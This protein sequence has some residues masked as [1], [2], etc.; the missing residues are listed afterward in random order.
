MISDL[1]NLFLSVRKESLFV[2]GPGSSLVEYKFECS[3]LN[4]PSPADDAPIRLTAIPAIQ[5]GLGRSARSEPLTQF[6]DLH[7][8][9]A[10][11]EGDVVAEE[12]GIASSP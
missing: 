10:E 5:W 8:L 4:R 9:S 2:L 12:T 11:E 3:P 7:L 6:L 1:P